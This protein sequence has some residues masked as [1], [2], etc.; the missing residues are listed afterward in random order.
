MNDFP[1]GNAARSTLVRYVVL[2][3]VGT[4]ALVLALVVAQHWLALSW[5]LVGAIVVAWIAKDVWLYPRVRHAYGPSEPA[6]S[7]MIGRTVVVRDGFEADGW[8]RAG[9]ELWRA[10]LAPGELPVASGATLQVRGVMGLTLIVA[11]SVGSGVGPAQE[12]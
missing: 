8:V 2:Q 11:R 3:A 5:W 9:H 7:R 12:S 6:A 10:R 1:P 4:I